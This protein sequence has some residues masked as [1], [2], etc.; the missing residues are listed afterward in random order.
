[1]GLEAAKARL[2]CVTSSDAAPFCISA[3]PQRARGGF[4]G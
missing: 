4:Y 1:M 2:A 3:L